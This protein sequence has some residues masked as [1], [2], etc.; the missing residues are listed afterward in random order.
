[1]SAVPR[2]A[3]VVSSS[4]SSGI[5]FFNAS[6]AKT[7]ASTSTPAK[8]PRV[9]SFHSGLLSMQPACDCTDL[10]IR[11][12]HSTI[13][14]AGGAPFNAVFRSLPSFVLAVPFFTLPI[15]L[16]KTLREE[17]SGCVLSAAYRHSSHSGARSFAPLA[18][19]NFLGSDIPEEPVL[20]VALCSKQGELSAIYFHRINAR[21]K[22]AFMWLS[23]FRKYRFVLASP[24][25]ARRRMDQGRAHCRIRSQLLT[26]LSSTCRRTSRASFLS[27]L[28]ATFFKPLF[29]D[30]RLFTFLCATSS[31]GSQ[32]SVSLHKLAN[33]LKLKARPS[34]LVRGGA[35]EG[36]IASARSC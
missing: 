18:V 23:T 2:T 4:S 27:S 10:P 5:G 17:L 16:G 20:S 24:R 15:F 7:Y 29:L 36:C 12:L 8:Q 32:R 25:H 1:M 30:A 26:L 6:A 13:R 35:L 28:Q 31:V 33:I 11:C 9:E 19:I 14:P 21:A 3:V 22:T 34:R